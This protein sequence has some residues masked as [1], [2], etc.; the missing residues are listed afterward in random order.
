MDGIVTACRVVGIPGLGLL[1]DTAAAAADWGLEGA[2][3]RTRM[4]NGMKHGVKNLLRVIGFF[5]VSLSAVHGPPSSSE[6]ARQLLPWQKMICSEGLHRMGQAYLVRRTDGS[7]DAKLP[8]WLFFRHAKAYLKELKKAS[9]LSPQVA[10]LSCYSRVVQ[11]SPLF[12]IWQRR[13]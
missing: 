6:Q 4:M 11:R 8:I 13:R 2:N 12:R 1:L 9:Q 5:C 7:S 10:A 3:F